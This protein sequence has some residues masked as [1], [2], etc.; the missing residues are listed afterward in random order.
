MAA[1]SGSWTTPSGSA[2][3][4]PKTAMFQ[5]GQAQP[6]QPT[7]A[8]TPYQAQANR[9]QPWAEPTGGHPQI[10]SDPFGAGAN[11]NPRPSWL[12]KQYSSKY[13]AA[14]PLA[15]Q[16]AY[17]KPYSSQ[18]GP[19]G[20]LASQDAYG[21]PVGG[22]LYNPRPSWLSPQYSSKYNADGAPAFNPRPPQ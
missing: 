6:K 4:P 10:N 12:S 1:F 11:A 2:W 20:P 8:G 5:T 13:N 18:Y 9:P 19:A 15:S 16:D 14:G 21:K 3:T 17:G 22:S 7:A